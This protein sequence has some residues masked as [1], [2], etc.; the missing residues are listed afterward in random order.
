[1]PA[2]LR[3]RRPGH[4]VNLLQ[5]NFEPL[6]SHRLHGEGYSQIIP[7][8]GLSIYSPPGEPFTL[9]ALDN[10]G[11][12]GFEFAVQVQAVLPG[13]KAYG[14]FFGYRPRSPDATPAAPFVLVR[15]EEQVA[16]SASPS[17]MTV[18][19]AL[20][21]NNQSQHADMVWCRP[22]PGLGGGTR[23]PPR[24]NKGWRSLRIH[25]NADGVTVAADEVSITL[26]MRKARFDLRGRADGL[27][28]LG[29]L[30]VWISGGAAFVRQ[31]T[32]AVEPSNEGRE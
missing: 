18:E 23:L 31:A 14:L 7:G 19:A 29:V 10:P 30:G 12:R 20:V 27:E 16:G 15:I 1:L 24:G 8:F 13:A 6:W 11:T 21:R 25:A 2:E 17:L 28:R 5:A 22:I 4:A 32:V 3:D 26:D 9:I